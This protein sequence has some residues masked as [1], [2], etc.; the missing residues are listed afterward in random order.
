M[1]RTPAAAVLLSTILSKKSGL[2][3]PNIVA[4]RGI[5]SPDRSRPAATK[6]PGMGFGV[7][8]APVVMSVV[9]VGYIYL[10]QWGQS[11][12]FADCDIMPV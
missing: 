8:T 6:S 2:G 9:L 5:T 11:T 10:A 7:I 4:R 12:E 3:M 1:T